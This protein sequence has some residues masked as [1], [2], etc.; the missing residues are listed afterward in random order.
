MKTI[1][2]STQ[3][4]MECFL[5]RDAVTFPER[6]AGGAYAPGSRNLPII[7]QPHVRAQTKIHLVWR[8]PTVVSSQAPASQSHRA[9]KAT[10]PCTCPHLKSPKAH[11]SSTWCPSGRISFSPPPA[12]GPIICGPEEIVRGLVGQ[13]WQKSLDKD[14]KVCSFPKVL[15]TVF[16]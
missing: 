14:D 15:Q 13:I 9:G 5:K 8:E 12:L 11:K 6:K 3:E 1:Q 16:K 7:W 2:E 10:K 4:N